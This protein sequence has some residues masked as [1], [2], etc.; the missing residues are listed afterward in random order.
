MVGIFMP[1]RLQSE[2]LPKKLTLPLGDTCLWEIACKKLSQIEGVN[3]YV[4]IN[5]GELI[6]IAKRFSDIEIIKRD[7]KTCEVDGPLT[8]I[9]KD[10]KLVPDKYLMFLNPCLYNLH[11]DT[12]QR[13]II[14]F[15][16][17]KS[18]YATS[19]KKFQ[20]WV[21]DANSNPVVPIDYQRLSTK[22]IPIYYQA[23]HCFHIFNKDEFF[24]TGMMLNEGLE[25]IVVQ[26]DDTLDVDTIEDFEVAQCLLQKSE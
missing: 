5:D 23:A 26:K 11:T 8:F 6:E 2:R 24:E 17:S 13:A 10:M 14:E 20:N 18:E 25:L 12:I 3:K 15:E 7:K 19:V 22:E 9:F 4:L 1:G 16:R 21:W